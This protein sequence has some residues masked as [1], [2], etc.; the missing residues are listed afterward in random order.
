MR[1]QSVMRG[2]G[3]KGLMVSP[4][5]AARYYTPRCH[6]TSSPWQTYSL[7]DNSTFTHGNTQ[8]KQREI[9]R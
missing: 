8:I 6:H 4:V 1:G 9:K 2:D 3:S 5:P 7:K